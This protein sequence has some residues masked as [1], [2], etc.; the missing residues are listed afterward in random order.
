[1]NLIEKVVI[2]DGVNADTTVTINLYTGQVDEINA[3]LAHPSIPNTRGVAAYS[4]V[5]NKPTFSFSAINPNEMWVYVDGIAIKCGGVTSL[6]QNDFFFYDGIVSTTALEANYDQ[7]KVLVVNEIGNYKIGNV[8]KLRAKHIGFMGSISYGTYYGEITDIN[9]GTKAISVSLINAGTNFTQASSEW[10]FSLVATDYDGL[11]YILL[12][13]QLRK[14]NPPYVWSPTATATKNL[15]SDSGA[16]GN[17]RQ[18]IVKAEFQGADTEPTHTIDIK[19]ANIS[20]YE[21]YT[22]SNLSEYNCNALILITTGGTFWDGTTTKN[23]FPNKG[24][25]IANYEF[26]NSIRIMKVGTIIYVV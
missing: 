1:M 8:V 17:A 19:V 18:I 21:I 5:G 14:Q 16:T 3:L 24:A 4:L 23:L 15:E 25:S 6:N 26:K 12:P 10:T 11:E 13:Y 20:E 2:K 9:T 22:I 7:V